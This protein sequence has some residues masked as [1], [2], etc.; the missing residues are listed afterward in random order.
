MFHQLH[1]PL[2]LS[3]NCKTKWAIIY[4]S[5]FLHSCCNSVTQIFLSVSLILCCH[6]LSSPNTH[7]LSSLFFFLL[8]LFMKVISFYNCFLPFYFSYIIFLNTFTYPNCSF[9]VF[10]ICSYLLVQI[11][12][13]SDQYSHVE[14]HLNLVAEFM[15]CMPCSW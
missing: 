4:C 13:I 8:Y 6:Q 1:V 12:D 3:N 11:P 5:I 9:P 10:L 15:T 7:L 2:P 14:R